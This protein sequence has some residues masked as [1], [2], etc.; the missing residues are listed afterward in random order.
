MKILDECGLTIISV[1]APLAASLE[2]HHAVA[3]VES[4][5]FRG[6]PGGPIAQLNR[7]IEID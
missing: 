7:P 2:F 3:F 1:E 6:I 4:V 5:S